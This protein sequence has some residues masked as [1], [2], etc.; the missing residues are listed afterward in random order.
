M[1]NEA[2]IEDNLDTGAH[3]DVH[4]LREVGEEGPVVLEQLA[5]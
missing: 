4:K 5:H 1:L 3:S 2:A